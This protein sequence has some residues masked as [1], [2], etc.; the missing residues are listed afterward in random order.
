M[1][2][3]E[4]A[5]P[6]GLPESEDEQNALGTRAVFLE[7]TSDIVA[8]NDPSVTKRCTTAFRRRTALGNMEHTD[9]PS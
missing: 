6:P 8:T 9:G 5:L 1:S 3:R 4:L 7:G 2:Q